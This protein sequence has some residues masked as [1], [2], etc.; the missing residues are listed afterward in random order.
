M[1]PVNIKSI[2]I[3][4]SVLSLIACGGGG[5]GNNS[6]IAPPSNQTPGMPNNGNPNGPNNGNPSGQVGSL[7]G[8]WVSNCVLTPALTSPSYIKK[9]LTFDAS[10]SIE[11]FD[12]FSDEN[13]VTPRKTAGLNITTFINRTY[14]TGSIVTTSDN[15]TAKEIDFSPAISV[16]NA[17]GETDSGAFLI[18]RFP[19]EIKPFTVF[20]MDSAGTLFFADRIFSASPDGLSAATRVIDIDAGIFYRKGL[21]A[22]GDNIVP[23]QPPTV[24]SGPVTLA[25]QDTSVIGTTFIVARVREKLFPSIDESQF[26]WEGQTSSAFISAELIVGRDISVPNVPTFVILEYFPSGS[27]VDSFSYTIDCDT[28]TSCGGI[29]LDTTQKTVTFNNLNL[30]AESNSFGTSLASGSIT[31]DGTLSWRQ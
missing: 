13:C 3:A 15:I 6:S 12:V 31:I 26:N 21:V 22:P 27:G 11:R 10:Q 5:S 9:T 30:P 14:T 17:T 7:S 25:G 16:T 18:A 20:T 2:A 1:E 28:P 24:G 23:G 19:E 29:S 8:R 4:L